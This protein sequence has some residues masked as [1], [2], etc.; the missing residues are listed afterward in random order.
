MKVILFAAFSHDIEFSTLLLKDS[1]KPV[2]AAI[3]GSCLG[4]GC[5]VCWKDFL[6][7][8]YL[9]TESNPFVESYKDVAFVFDSEKPR[10]IYDRCFSISTF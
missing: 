10:I 8:S 6:K 4:G 5:E 1:K 9:R 7:L 2:V 3:S